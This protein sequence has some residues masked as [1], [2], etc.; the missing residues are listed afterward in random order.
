MLRR[1]K[2]V[3]FSEDGSSRLLK[4]IGTQIRNTRRYVSGGP[5]LSTISDPTNVILA[6]KLNFI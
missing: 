2:L 4:N 6:R 5:N 3:F 1:N